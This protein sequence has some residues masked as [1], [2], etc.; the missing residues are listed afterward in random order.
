MIAGVRARGGERQIFRHNDVAHLEQ[1]LA[2]R[3]AAPKLVA[4]ESVYSMDGDIA[5]WPQ[6]ARSPGGTG[7]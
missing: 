6:S 1:L 3:P 4:F 5:R 7:R 2:G